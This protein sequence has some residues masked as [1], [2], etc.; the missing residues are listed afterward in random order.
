MLLL[1]AVP[2][3]A[4]EAAQSYTYDDNGEVILTPDA[5]KFS[6]N[7]D[8]EMLKTTV[9]GISDVVIAKGEIYLVDSGN[10]RILIT[11]LNGNFIRS[12]DSYSAD[13]IIHTFKKP[14]GLFVTGKAKP[15]IHP[16][17]ILTAAAERYRIP[18]YQGG[19]C[20]K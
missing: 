11:G 10:N 3:S 17:P 19:I 2:V 4:K 7:I 6:Y 14:S 18:V 9:S 5:A 20:Q 15:E 8:D 16:N 1:S 12:V 13:G